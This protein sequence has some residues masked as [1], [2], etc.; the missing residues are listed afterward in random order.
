[1][2]CLLCEAQVKDVSTSKDFDLDL[3]T[4]DCEICG[5]YSITYEASMAV[6]EKDCFEQR[7]RISSFIKEKSIRKKKVLICVND[8]TNVDTSTFTVKYIL[9]QYPKTMKEKLV[10]ILKNLTLVS[11]HHGNAIALTSSEYPLLFPGSFDNRIEESNYILSELVKLGYIT[12]SAVLPTK[13]I[14]TSSAWTLVESVT[15]EKKTILD[16]NPKEEKLLIV[17]KPSI[18]IGSSVENLDVAYAIQN[19]LE[20]DGEPT[21]WTQGV[22]QL[23]STTIRDLLNIMDIVDFSVFVFSPD[24]MTKIRD[25]EMNT[26]RDNVIFEMGLFIGRLGVERTFFI[27]PQGAENL[28]LPTDLI[29]IEPG[30]YI[31]NRADGNLLA[32]LG[33]VCNNIRRRIKVL[34]IK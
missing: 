34:G 31:S 24:D 3:K 13:V 4:C 21:V 6:K 28:H 26:V 15:E 29:G 30:R 22:F 33:P 27:I 5:R 1:M 17:K 7:S 2:Y 19:N 23:S 16:V 25:K 11:I 20:H 10:R 8:E 12:G 9:D 18:F 14:L 32:S